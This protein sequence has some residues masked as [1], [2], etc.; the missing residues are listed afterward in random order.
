MQIRIEMDPGVLNNVI[1]GDIYFGN[2][3]LTEGTQW[4]PLQTHLDFCTPE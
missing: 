1:A 4:Q 2:E 3:M